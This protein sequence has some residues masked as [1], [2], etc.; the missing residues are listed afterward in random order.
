M[1]TDD[2]TRVFYR[3]HSGEGVVIEPHPLPSREEFHE[4]GLAMSVRK[5]RI[6]V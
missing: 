5:E 4:L 3:L 2:L 6:R 1:P